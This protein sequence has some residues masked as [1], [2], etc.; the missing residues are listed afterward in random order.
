M[1]GIDAPELDFPV[2][3]KRDPSKKGKY[4]DFRQP[5]GASAASGLHAYLQSLLPSG[6]G[7]VIQAR[8]VTQIDKPGNAID[9]HGRFVGDIIVGTAGGKSIN[10]WMVEHGWAYPLF[11]DS[12]TAA[13]ITTLLAAWKT[14]QAVAARPGKA[15]QKALQTFRPERSVETAELPDSGKLNLPKIFRRQAT[16]WTEIAG[17]L[18]AAQFVARLN[19]K[20]PG[21][22][23]KAYFLDYFLANMNNLNSKKRVT[24]AS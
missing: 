3:G 6:G 4:P 8:F 23:D 5:Y 21:K 11:Y 2:I 14:G 20:T 17:P 13:E 22:P 15:L 12:M 10:T 24:L 1:Q 18:S 19:K 7:T 16:F 9:S